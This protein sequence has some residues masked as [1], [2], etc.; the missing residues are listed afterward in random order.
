MARASPPSPQNPAVRLTETKRAALQ[1]L[2]H[3]DSDRVRLRALILLLSAQGHSGE[4]I[5][6]LLGI[7]RRMVSRTRTRWREHSIKGIPDQPRPGR[8]PKV[9]EAYLTELF[10]CV[11]LD[12]RSLGYAFTRW[13]APRLAAYL[14][15]KTDISISADW[16]AELLQ[17]QS[18]A[19]RRTRQTI[20][21]KQN[22]K[23]V[24]RAKK[25]LA[26]LK[27]RASERM[28][29]SSFGSEMGS[30]SNSCQS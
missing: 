11:A 27:K 4:Y 2:V 6:E 1:K 9:T 20:K 29:A 19:W 5:S 12:P 28:P 24:K 18:Y 13:T 17:A 10:R 14:Y 26:E 7:S 30:S 15:Q 8:P 21:N 3:A 16:V 25:E 23:E 22:P